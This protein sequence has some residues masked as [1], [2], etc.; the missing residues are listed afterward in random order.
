MS[1]VPVM[2]TR[3]SAT[4]GLATAAAVRGIFVNGPPNVNAATPGGVA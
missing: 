2:V 1:N 4:V 3:S